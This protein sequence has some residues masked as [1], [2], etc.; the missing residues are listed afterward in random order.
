MATT[1]LVA[2]G[3]ILCSWARLLQGLRRS[4]H[5]G[6]CRFEQQLREG[7]PTSHTLPMW[8]ESDAGREPGADPEMRMGRPMSPNVDLAP[9]WPWR[10]P[11]EAEAGM[12]QAQRGRPPMR[13]ARPALLAYPGGTGGGGGLAMDCRALKAG[14][15]P[16]DCAT[17]CHGGPEFMCRNKLEPA[18]SDRPRPCRARGR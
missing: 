9:V 11:I 3:T 6:R 13:R 12:A 5:R 10:P 18:R 16:A 8:L 7:I 1:R 15:L 2:T 17:E 14:V 4:R